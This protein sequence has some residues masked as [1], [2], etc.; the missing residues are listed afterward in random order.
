M[1]RWGH[2]GGGEWELGTGRRREGGEWE[3][4]LGGEELGAVPLPEFLDAT[5]IR[6]LAA[7]K[8]ERELEG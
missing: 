6:Q 5:D 3:V 1:S 8:D 4:E 2:S 7:K